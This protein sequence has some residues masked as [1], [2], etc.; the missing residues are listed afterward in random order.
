MLALAALAVSAGLSRALPRWLCG[1]GVALA[2]AIVASGVGYLLLLNGL[3][4]AAWMSLPLLMVWVTG[5][6]VVLGSRRHDLC[7]HRPTAPGPVSLPDNELDPVCD[8][9]L[10]RTH[11]NGKKTAFRVVLG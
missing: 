5:T 9:H 8:R 11:R 2:V 10:R 7:G 1:V 4:L 6:G 3:A